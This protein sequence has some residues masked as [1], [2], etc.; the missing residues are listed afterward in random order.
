MTFMYVLT[1]S[2]NPFDIHC[3]FV[4]CAIPVISVHDEINFVFIIVCVT[5]TMAWFASV[6]CK[7]N[8]AQWMHT[9]VRPI[10]SPGL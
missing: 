6:V 7:P 5:P 9:V 2:Q 1:Q 10:A 8:W 3:F 4:G